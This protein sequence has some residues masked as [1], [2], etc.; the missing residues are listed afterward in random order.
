MVDSLHFLSYLL[1]F[2]GLSQLFQGE[3]LPLCPPPI[4]YGDE[5]HYIFHLEGPI[6]VVVEL[7]VVVAVLV[8]L[9][10][11]LLVVVVV[12]WTQLGSGPLLKCLCFLKPSF[13]LASAWP[14]VRISLLSPT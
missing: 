10:L 7:V 11:L 1:D 6:E 5:R 13:S 8:L 3:H 2:D 12:R 14:N 4:S 9:L